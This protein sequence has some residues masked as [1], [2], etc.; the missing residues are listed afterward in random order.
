MN[1]KGQSLVIFIIFLPLIFLLIAIIYDL[2]SLE[3]KKQKN[4][5]EIKSAITYG[6]NNIDDNDINQ[7]INTILEKNISAQKTV[8]INN[9][10]ITINAYLKEK[11]IF[12][13]ILKDDYQINLNYKG[14]IENGKIIIE[15]E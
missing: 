1:N 11:S 9:N 3:L 15:K 14:Y 7:N 13:N 2:G 10:I 12:P 4:I 6:L 8:T 5:N